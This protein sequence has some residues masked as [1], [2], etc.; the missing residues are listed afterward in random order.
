M[1]RMRIWHNIGNLMESLAV[2][3]INTDDNIQIMINLDYS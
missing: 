2:D 1:K 3:A